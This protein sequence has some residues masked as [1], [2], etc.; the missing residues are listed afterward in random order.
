MAA[1]RDEYRP[2]IEPGE[3]P[4][5]SPEAAAHEQAMQ[6]VEQTLLNIEAAL[7]RADRGRK[8]ISPTGGE[9]NLRQ[10]LDRAVEQLEGARKELFREG[11]FGGQQERLI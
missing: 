4:E 2:L 11:Y 10:A 8:A 6:E 5:R 1:A 9:R 7:R 3:V